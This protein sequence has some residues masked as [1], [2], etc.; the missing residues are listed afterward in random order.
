MISA[1]VLTKNEEKN[2]VDCLE[3]LSFVK[4]IIVIDDYSTDR[5]LELVKRM[6]AI[7]YP[8]ELAND[9]ATQRNYGLE[10]AKGE[11]VLFIDADE[12]VTE[13]LKNE[14]IYK[15]RKLG[16]EDN[17]GFR[18]KRTDMMFG[19]KL[20]HGETG[21][22]SFVRLARKDRGKW[23]GKVHETWNIKGK[24]ELLESELLHFP[25]PTIREFLEEINTYTDIRAKELYEQKTPVS[26]VSIVGYPMGKFI[27]NYFVKRGFLDGTEG[28]LHAFLMSLHSFL[29]RSKLWQHYQTK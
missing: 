23:I 19:K 1:V 13:N 12:Q 9:Y 20:E 8:R 22:I 7:V 28:L 27:L 29:V 10:K 5:T 17:A 15:T 14:I 2:I 6:N 25:H 3:S 18:I 26:V 16:N 4:E 24:I 11:W 21:N